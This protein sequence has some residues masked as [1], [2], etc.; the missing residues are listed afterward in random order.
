MKTG[1]SNPEIEEACATVTSKSKTLVG[2]MKNR[3]MEVKR[4]KR[5]SLLP[6]PIQYL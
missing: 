2:V 5:T 3:M 6:L 1:G 4:E